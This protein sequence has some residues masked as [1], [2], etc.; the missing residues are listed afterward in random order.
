MGSYYC[1]WLRLV[2]TQ[3]CLANWLRHVVLLKLTWLHSWVCHETWFNVKHIKFFY[4]TPLLVHAFWKNSEQVSRE[5]KVAII[6]Y[7]SLKPEVILIMRNQHQHHDCEEDVPIIS[8]GEITTKLYLYVI[9]TLIYY[10]VPY[11][12]KRWRD[13]TLANRSF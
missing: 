9:A 1:V 11:S 13:K 3:W 7:G 2:T 5:F 4:Y 10:S 12:A 8:N 6:N